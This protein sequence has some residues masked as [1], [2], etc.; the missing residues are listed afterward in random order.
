MSIDR[1]TLLRGPGKAVWNTTTLFSEVTILAQLITEY[2]DVPTSAFG[3]LGRRVKSKRIEVTL[4]PK[5]WTDLTIIF[6]YATANIG[7]QIFGATDLPLVITPRN[8]APLTI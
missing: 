7:D 3:R 4:T 6:P 2:F 8:G 5:M 1:T